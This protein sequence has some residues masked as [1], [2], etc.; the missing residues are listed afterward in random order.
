MSKKIG[1]F[2]DI[3]NLYYSV[4]NK[5][6]NR[7]L[8]YK[9]FYDFI[10]NKESGVG[11]VTLATAYGAQLNEEAKPFIN[12]LRAIGFQPKYKQIK[13]YN[14]S[15]HVKSKG[16]CDIDIVVD[17]VKAIANLDVVVLG[18]ADSD[19]L[20]LVKWVQDQ[21]KSVIIIACGISKELRE[22]C[23]Q[24]IEIPESMIEMPKGSIDEVPTVQPGN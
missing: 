23:I 17:V 11:E 24:T 13:V 4:R 3:S 20:P 2:I 14:N 6:G 12:C 1:I 5:Y 9:K 8:D 10:G 18:S 7:K 15:G 19:F 21:G 22:N 16:N